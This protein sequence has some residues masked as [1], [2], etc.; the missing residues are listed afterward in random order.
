MEQRRLMWT[1]SYNLEVWFSTWKDLLVDLGFGRLATVE[2]NVDGEI[3]FFDG[4]TNR[5]INVDETD[6]SLDD[7]T[8]QRGGR[9]PMTFFA[10]DIA[11]GGTA[12]NKSG[13]SCTVICGSTASGDPLPAHFQLKTLAQTVQG[14]RISIDWFGYTKKVI[15][16][17]GFPTRR[18]VP[19]TFGMN[20][21]AGMNAVELDKYMKN[22]ILPLYPDIQD[23]PGKRVL[24]KVDSGPGRLN[25]EMLAD[26]RLHGLYLVPGVPNTTHQTQETDQNYGIY[27][28]SFRENLRNLSQCRFENSLTLQVADLPLLVFGGECPSTGLPL[29]DAFSDAFSIE[30]N[31]IAGRS[32]VPFR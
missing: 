26:L 6:G 1:T 28:S 11:G 29:R 7:T 30:R 5:I 32:V 15:G 8:G 16:T 10:P 25:I 3:F 19:C 9:P 14:Q 24:L 12:V 2:D 17:F 13:Y 27:K 4:M 18:A 21:R 23:V 31:L 22:A 20:E